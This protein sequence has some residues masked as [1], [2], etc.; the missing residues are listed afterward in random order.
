MLGCESGRAHGLDRM[1]RLLLLG[2]S[3]AGLPVLATSALAQAVV[4]GFDANQLAR[5]DDGS[6]GAVSLPFAANFFGATYSELYVNNNGN[7][8]FGSPLSQ[9]TPTGLGAGYRGAPIIAPFFSDV[10]TRNPASGVTSYGTGTYAG[11]AAF[12]VTWPGVGYFDSHADKTNTFQLI[13]A[14]R[15]DTGSG[16]FDIYFNYARIQFETGDASGGTNGLG[17]TSAAAGYSAGTGASGTYYEIPGSLVNGAFLDGGPN[18]L[19]TSSNNGVPGQFL[20]PVRNGVVLFANV[21]QAGDNASTTT[22]ANCGPN[23]SYTG[24][25]FYTPLNNFTLNVLD[26]T[27]ITGGSGSA[28]LVMPTTLSEGGNPAGSV[29]V[30]VN[31]SAT[32]NA[33][34]GAGIEIDSHAG[35]GAG[36]VKSAGTIT[37]ATVGILGDTNTGAVTLGNAGTITA[38]IGISGASRTLTSLSNTGTITASYA[39]LVGGAFSGT[40]AIDNSGTIGFGRFGIL[41]GNVS[42]PL[43]LTN[44]GALT[45]TG[46]PSAAPATGLPASIAASVPGSGSYGI[47]ARGGAAISILNGPSGTITAE[48]GIDAAVLTSAPGLPAA[49][50]LGSLN[51]TNLGTITATGAAIT[52]ASSAVASQVTNAGTL[53]GSIALSNGSSFTNTETGRVNITGPSSFGGGTL[54]NAGGIS[55]ASTSL[56]GLSSFTNQSGGL[57]IATGDSSI[58]SQT[59]PA[60]VINAGTISLVNGHAGD[61]LTINGNYTGRNGLLAVEF[62]TQT[63]AS[64]RLVING[65]AS[66]STGVVVTNLTQAVPFTTG[67]PFVTVTG[68]AAANAFTLAGAQNFGTLEAVLVSSANTAGGTSIGIGAVPTAIGLSA[69]TAVIAARTI[70]FQ[71]GTAVLDRVTQL[72]DE[73]RQVDSGQPSMPQALQYNGLSQYSA[74]VTKDPIAPKLAEPAPQTT[75]RPAVWARAYGDFESRSGFSSFSFAGQNFVRDLG[76]SQT[77]GGFLAGSDVVISGLTKPD[78]GLILGVMGGYTLAGVDLNRNAGRQDYEGG[79]VGVYGTYLNGPWFWDAQ[80]KVDLLGLDITAPGLRQRTGLQNYYVSTNVGYRIPLEHNIYVEP[81]AG[82]EYVSTVFDRTPALGA[83]LVPL[84]DGDAL[85]G[86]IGARVGTEFVQ[87]DIRIEP[88]ITGYV[89]SVLT[90]SGTLGAFTGGITSVTGLREEGKVR[91]EVQASINFF[92]LKTGLSGFIRGDYRVGGDLVAGGGRAGIRYQFSTF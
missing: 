52:T 3:F 89:Y 23:R 44:T 56:T 2:V 88:S 46:T 84:R 24:G 29:T 30:N 62:A 64:D 85:R 61:T 32:I 9:F 63:S 20:F 69:P 58:G 41:G 80:F 53:T 91:G 43:T 68:T 10:D 59:Q 66:G 86:R 42:G 17:G 37:A 71:G 12:G 72:R 40:V 22:T 16:N 65:N 75:T 45:Q 25:I 54:S 87:D 57:L 90:E 11:R 14:S 26:N 18:A 48:T 82:L 28:V 83:N 78:D 21:C 1:R 92:N 36:I 27:T 7:V 8:T 34:G 70:A 6:T 73:K 55:L 38:P 39:G 50:S 76:Y 31:A 4:P 49:A 5:N 33:P 79:T 19:A 51:I 60:S 67:A 77:S 81:T 47:F 35:S 74:L 13:M 15:P